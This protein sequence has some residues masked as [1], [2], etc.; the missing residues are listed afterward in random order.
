MAKAQRS[1]RPR[2]PGVEQRA[3]AAARTVYAE[4]GWSGFSL[5]EV[6]RRSGIGKGSL[7][8]RWPDKAALLV[9]A[10]RERAGF[11]AEIDTGSLREDLLA[12]ARGWR[13]YLRTDEGV[14]I[15][16]LSV[17]ATFSPRLAEAF[18][19]DPYPEH[20]RATRAIVRRGINRGELPPDTSVALV[21]DLV[22]G[23][24]TNHV[25]TTPAHLLD[26]QNGDH[27]V[28]LVDVVL[29]GTRKRP[30]VSAETSDL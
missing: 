2:D 9:A 4:R 6:A 15:F 7:Y 27:V 3:L 16:R 19:E 5:D 10:V 29:A 26:S 12:F 23:A 18:A 17:D 1:G 25:H 14:L 24:V 13:D 30:E 8:L 20:I 28:D 21:A 11:I 22:A